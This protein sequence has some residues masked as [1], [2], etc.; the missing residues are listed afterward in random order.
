MPN[1]G[2]GQ[3]ILSNIKNRSGRFSAR[4]VFPAASAPRLQ[5]TPMLIWRQWIT[6]QKS[7]L[8]PVNR[9]ALRFIPAKLK[10]KL[11]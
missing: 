11:F 10:R 2:N 6:W 1:A 9:R 7:P 4:L 5:R 8:S 3:D